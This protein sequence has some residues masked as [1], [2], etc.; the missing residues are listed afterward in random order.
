MDNN[1]SVKNV[2]L[3][4]FCLL[5]QKKQKNVLKICQI[6]LSLHR[7]NKKMTTNSNIALISLLSLRLTRPQVGKACACYVA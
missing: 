1:D 5:M 6:I 2:Q 3:C 7:N 4:F